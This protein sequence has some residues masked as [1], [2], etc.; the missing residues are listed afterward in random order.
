M[1]IMTQENLEI[2]EQFLL[3]AIYRAT[4]GSTNIHP[5]EEVIRKY[6]PKEAK[7]NNK[8]AQRIRRKAVKNLKSKGL[9]TKHPTADKD[10]WNITTKGTKIA[11]KL[12]QS[13][14][15]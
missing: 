3:I 2:E 15:Q 9:I 11:K 7:E 14:F 8:L 4:H 5:S 6:L 13:S 1:V 12:L 10:T